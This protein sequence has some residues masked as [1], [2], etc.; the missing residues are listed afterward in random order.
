MS[1]SEVG[2][3]KDGTLIRYLQRLEDNLRHQLPLD[4]DDHGILQICLVSL[5]SRS[6][7]VKKKCGEIKAILLSQQQAKNDIDNPKKVNFDLQFDLTRLL[8]LF[9]PAG[10]LA[11]ERAVIISN[12]QNDAMVETFL[13]KK[14]EKEDAEWVPV[15]T[16]QFELKYL[17]EA[18]PQQPAENPPPPQAPEVSE[19]ELLMQAELERQIARDLLEFHWVGSDLM[20]TEECLRLELTQT[21]HRARQI[22][23]LSLSGWRFFQDYLQPMLPDFVKYI[24]RLLKRPGFAKQI[25]SL[26]AQSMFPQAPPPPKAA[27]SPAK[28]TKFL[29]HTLTDQL[30]G[31][32]KTLERSLK[33]DEQRKEFA[34]LLLEMLDRDAKSPLSPTQRDIMHC[35]LSLYVPDMLHAALNA[36]IPKSENDEVPVWLSQLIQS[37]QPAQNDNRHETLMNIFCYI[38]EHQLS[39]PLE[40]AT[41]ALLSRLK[42][43]QITDLMLQKIREPLIKLFFPE[44]EN[45][46]AKLRHIITEVLT[47]I[48]LFVRSINTGTRSQTKEPVSGVE[49][50]IGILQNMVKDLLGTLKINPGKGKTHEENLKNL[51]EGLTNQFESLVWTGFYPEIPP[52]FD[53]A[54]PLQKLVV[55]VLSALGHSLAESL[56]TSHN[57]NLLIAR[58]LN[59]PMTFDNPFESPAPPLD[60]FNAD[61][62]DFSKN[63]DALIHDI[64]AQIIELEFEGGLFNAIGQK[65][66]NWILN[67]VP[68]GLRIQQALN[69]LSNSDA[70]LL[71]VLVPIQFLYQIR[72]VKPPNNGDN[73][74]SKAVQ[75]EQQDLHLQKQFFKALCHPTMAYKVQTLVNPSIEEKIALQQ[76]LD[77]DILI[78]P[79][80]IEK[81]LKEILPI[82]TRNAGLDLIQKLYRLAR[83]DL[84]IKILM[85]YVI[86][87][88]KQGLLYVD[89]PLPVPASQ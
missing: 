33:D 50:E 88:F 70:T 14:A 87:G 3:V 79:A 30:R 2:F 40:K 62:A 6:E 41:E 17:L 59:Q 83:H 45:T 51:N 21:N 82:L 52:P 11:E 72:W 54:S 15:L 29:Q 38:I 22:E 69:R 27:N 7:E 55:M 85:A 23:L 78:R 65:L 16:E 71:P 89:K 77:C 5:E 44:P 37:F 60:R 24:D 57:L 20:L 35:I 47:R 64:A 43:D 19:I 9:D 28:S 63:L 68:A 34:D 39:L 58:L 49:P 76:A 67:W 13:A 48:L 73:K 75:K 1:A 53:K 31:F 36:C 66:L 46:T 4:Y 86:E 74:L 42:N 61:D 32:A 81:I 18:Q 25:G 12:E 26:L 8:K 56:L 80:R 10:A 84:F